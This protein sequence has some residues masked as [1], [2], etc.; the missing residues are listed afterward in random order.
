MELA[1]PPLLIANNTLWKHLYLREARIDCKCILDFG[2]ES[3][4]VRSISSDLFYNNFFHLQLMPVD[5]NAS[6]GY[7]FFYF[8]CIH[9]YLDLK[10]SSSENHLHRTKADTYCIMWALLMD[11][12]CPP[13]KRHELLSGYPLAFGKT[14]RILWLMSAS[15]LVQVFKEIIPPRWGHTYASILMMFICLSVPPS[16]LLA[17]SNR[18]GEKNPKARLSRSR[19]FANTFQ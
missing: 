10:S 11:R 6:R 12:S 7:S 14:A 9:T 2:V 8:N 1:N 17:T 18:S 13:W 15:H 16:V 5:W 3:C 4:S 19:A